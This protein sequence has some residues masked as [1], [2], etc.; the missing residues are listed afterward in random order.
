MFD[1]LVRMHI[2][3]EYAPHGE[4]FTKLTTFGKLSEKEAKSNLSQ[5]VSAVSHMVRAA[6]SVCLIHIT[7]YQ[8]IHLH[9]SDL[10]L[11][12]KIDE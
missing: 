1:N 6:L 4:L 7:T 5:I 12:Y 8:Y 3:M 2:V 9:L 11:S 10:S